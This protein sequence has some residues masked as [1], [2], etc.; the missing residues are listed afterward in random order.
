MVEFIHA[1][2]I[3]VAIS[4]GLNLLISVIASYHYSDFKISIKLSVCCEMCIGKYLLFLVCFA[5][6]KW[7]IALYRLK[8]A[9]QVSSL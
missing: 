5:R 1:D 8:G 3:L 6:Q 9:I 4:S 2:N 7:E